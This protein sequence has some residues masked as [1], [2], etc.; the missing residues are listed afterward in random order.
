MKRGISASSPPV[1]AKTV[2]IL[3]LPESTASVVFGMYDLLISAGRD[4]GIVVDGEPGAALIVPRIVAR[5][6]GPFRAANG[7]TIEPQAT[8]DDV[9]TADVVCVPELAVPPD[10]DLSGRFER[11]V[12]W[13]RAHHAAGAIVASACSGALLLAEAG[14]LD[15]EDATTHWGYCDALKRRHPRVRVHP[16]R[17]LVMAGPG[18][19]LLMAGGGTTWFHMALHLIAR[20]A[21][22][23]VAHAVARLHLIDWQPVAQQPFARLAATRP[24]SDAVVA[25]AQAWAAAHFTEPAPVAAMAR[26]SGLPERTFARRFRAALGVSP[27]AYVHALRLEAAKERLEA[28][29]E[30]VESIAFDVGYEDA[31]FFRRLF[32]RH[33]RL[34]PAEY[35]KRFG[36]LRRDLEATRAISDTALA[37]ADR[38]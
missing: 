38:H 32:R 19:R 24:A 12:A 7:V 20:L 13:L 23:D 37:A 2:A 26:A 15:G 21:G 14:L 8:I 30:P 29:H 36:A 25:Q 33:V 35:R 28:G 10:A 11:E 1:S 31:A 18:Q 22:C 9:P 17:A 6:A 16:D 27:L 5:K 34:T 4:W 3:A